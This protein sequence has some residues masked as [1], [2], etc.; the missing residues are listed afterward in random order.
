MAEKLLITAGDKSAHAAIY[1]F[2]TVARLSFEKLKTESLYG[3]LGPTKFCGCQRPRR[4]CISMNRIRLEPADSAEFK[5][6]RSDG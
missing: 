3:L 2:R 1:G 5:R 6:T 4:V